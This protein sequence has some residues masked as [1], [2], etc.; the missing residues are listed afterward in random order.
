MYFDNTRFPLFKTLKTI[1][2]L[3]NLIDECYVD[4]LILTASPR[5]LIAPVYL[6][7]VK[8]TIYSMKK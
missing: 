6:S 7:N 1:I 5:R 4:Q 8:K 3:N 2:N